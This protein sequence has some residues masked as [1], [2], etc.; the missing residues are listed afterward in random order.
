MKVRIAGLVAS[1]AICACLAAAQGVIGGVVSSGTRCACVKNMPYSAETISTRDQV[2]ADGNRI[3]RENHGKSYRDS[4]GR[5]RNETEMNVPAGT[6]PMTMVHIFDPEK[7]VSIQ[8]D[9]QRQ[10]ATINHFGQPEPP[11]Q[12]QQTPAQ[13]AAMQANRPKISREDLGTQTIEGVPA[14]GWRT[15]RTIPAGAEGNDAPLTIVSETWTAEDL[16]LTVLNK[17]DDPR[18]GAMETRYVNVQRVE[19]DPALF[20]I[21]ADYKVKDVPQ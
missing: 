4:E 11:V 1:I 6:P 2:L 21:P 9:E 17:T 8:L 3:H 7:K 12:R 14:H 19:P 18:G 10:V 16:H 13:I 15:T 5:T 20:Q